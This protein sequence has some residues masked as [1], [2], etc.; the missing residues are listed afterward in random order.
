MH[1]Y[2]DI[3]KAKGKICKNAVNNEILLHSCALHVSRP[4][5]LTRIDT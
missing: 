2:T 5:I 4:D 3:K 1:T